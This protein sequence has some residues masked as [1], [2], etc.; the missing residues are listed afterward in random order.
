MTSGARCVLLLRGIN[1]GAARRVPMAE[2]RTLL[3]RAGH[4]QVATYLQSGNIVLSSPAPVAELESSV[5]ALIAERFG[6]AVPVV[7]RTAQ[8]LA[9]VV[10]LNPLG[11]VATEPR[12][13]QVT[14]LAAPVS[15]AVRAKVRSAVALPER[16]AFAGREVY[17][18][19]PD[20]VA[21]SRLWNALGGPGL[22]VPA[23]TRNWTTV[24]TLAEMAGSVAP[25]G[26]Q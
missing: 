21:R 12:R 19:H 20:G 2:L 13:H 9:A 7:G 6:F 22:G 4:E 11:D 10:A 1:L 25:G 24:V 16:V 23:T 17:A 26:T 15:G 18:W 8:E 14:F 5:A 3:T